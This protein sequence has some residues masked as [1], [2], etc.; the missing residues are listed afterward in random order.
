MTKVC[1]PVCVLLCDCCPLSGDH[2][3]VWDLHR[4]NVINVTC[5]V[6]FTVNDENEAVRVLPFPVV[7]QRIYVNVLTL[8]NTFALIRFPSMPCSMICKTHTEQSGLSLA[9]DM[10]TANPDLRP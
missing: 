9:F 6:I 3:S 4:D 10:E 8:P 1:T 7:Y 5:F 2:L